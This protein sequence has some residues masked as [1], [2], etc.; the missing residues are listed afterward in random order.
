MSQ[1]AS[2]SKNPIEDIKV[3]ISVII[4]LWMLRAS[5]AEPIK[6]SHV[7][8]LMLLELFQIQVPPTQIER[9]SLSVQQQTIPKIAVRRGDLR[10]HVESGESNPNIREAEEQPNYLLRENNNYLGP[11]QP[12]LKMPFK[13]LLHETGDQLFGVDRQLTP[14]SAS[15][16]VYHENIGTK[17]HTNSA[18]QLS[19][20]VEASSAIITSYANSPS[21][22]NRPLKSTELLFPDVCPH[23]PRLC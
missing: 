2:Q 23:R 14:V 15:L 16:S 22:G 21:N 19:S 3:A 17:Y 18:L 20:P 12:S 6:S 9:F 5:S 1:A 10:S 13:T 7:S 4:H 8:K 11:K